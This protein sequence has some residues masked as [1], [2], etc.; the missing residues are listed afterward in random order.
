MQNTITMVS[1]GSQ[2]SPGGE[3]E[4]V[5]DV[6][7]PVTGLLSEPPAPVP[8][9]QRCVHCLEILP[10][11]RSKHECPPAAELEAILREIAREIE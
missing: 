1:E 3:V 9:P 5:S 11:G 10:I 4:A 8:E 2:E 6:S 7:F